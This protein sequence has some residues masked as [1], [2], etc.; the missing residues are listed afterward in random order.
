MKFNW[1]TGIAALYLG[2]VAMILLLVGMST[3]QKIDL[4]TDKYYDEELKFQDKINKTNRANSLEEPLKWQVTEQGL[5]ILFPENL[6]QISGNV[7]LYCPS[8][9]K[10]D[11]SFAI[12]QTGHSQLIPSSKIPK[13]RYR[14]QID[15]KSGENTYWSEDVIVMN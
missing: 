1:G 3:T 6:D 8:N 5:N 4:V 2:F 10:N 11:R 14:L 9:D 12:E 13:G 7:K 15:W